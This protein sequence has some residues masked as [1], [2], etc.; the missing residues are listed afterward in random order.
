MIMSLDLKSL[1]ETV[2]KLMLEEIE[3]DNKNNTL[4]ISQRLNEKGKKTYLELLKES[5]NSGNDSILAYRLLNDSCMAEKELRKK[6]NGGFSEVSV[7]YNANETLAEG[8]FNR[9][10]MR[11]LCLR[12]IKD[13]KGKLKVYRAKQVNNARQESMNKIGQIVDPEKLLS[14]LRANVGS[15]TALGLP[16]GPN[17][18]LSIEII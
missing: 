15:D 12:V 18:G 9:F 11:A 4:Y 1:D 6:K 16:P 7:P 3:L 5:A 8:E 17:S 10:Y 13:G 2:R 14:D